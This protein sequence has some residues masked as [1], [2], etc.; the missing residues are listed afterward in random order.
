MLDLQSSHSCTPYYDLIPTAIR[1]STAK[2]S[3]SCLKCSSS[4]KA[5]EVQ[6]TLHHDKLSIALLVLRSW[7]IREGELPKVAW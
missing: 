4:S 5:K 2:I 7:P 3:V 1:M 6:T